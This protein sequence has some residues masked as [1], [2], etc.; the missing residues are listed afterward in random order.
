[1][2]AN[3]L[4]PAQTRAL[5]N[6]ILCYSLAEADTRFHNVTFK[7][8]KTEEDLTDDTTLCNIQEEILAPGAEKQYPCYHTLTGKIVQLQMIGI[9]ARQLHVQEIEVHGYLNVNS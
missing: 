8:A 2:Q 3:G 7:V 5:S 4:R 1:M 9:P 6:P